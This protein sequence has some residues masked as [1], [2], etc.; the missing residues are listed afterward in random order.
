MS[1]LNI[2]DQI[3]NTYTDKFHPEGNY[4]LKNKD[5][6]IN[7]GKIGDELDAETIGDTLLN[8]YPDIS[9]HYP[10]SCDEWYWRDIGID[11]ADAHPEEFQ[12]LSFA[13]YEKIA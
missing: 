11:Y 5:L 2:T 13:V 1:N 10:F 4:F 8:Q 12:E 9:N 6:H 3:L 7:I